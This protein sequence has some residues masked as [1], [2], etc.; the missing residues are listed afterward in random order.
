LLSQQPLS[1]STRIL[2]FRDKKSIS[3]LKL[4]ITKISNRAGCDGS[5]LYEKVVRPYF[6]NKLEARE[7]TSDRVSDYQVQRPEF[8]TQYSQKKPGMVAQACNLRGGGQRIMI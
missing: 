4:L 7:M 2:L 8:K 6:K 1:K 5:C 3:L